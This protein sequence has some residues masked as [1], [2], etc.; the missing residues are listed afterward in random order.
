LRRFV[1]ANVPPD[2]SKVSNRAPDTGERLGARVWNAAAK[3]RRGKV[4]PAPPGS[5]SA[6][7][8]SVAGTIFVLSLKSFL[9]TES[10]FL[11]RLESST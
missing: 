8:P 2:G 5:E 1:S 4:F 11:T 7:Q 9:S 6:M 3:L 10:A